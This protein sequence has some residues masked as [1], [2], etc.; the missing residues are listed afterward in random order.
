MK[1][2]TYTK[3]PNSYLLQVFLLNSVQ[4]CSSCMATPIITHQPSTYSFTQKHSNYEQL[5]RY[6]LKVTG[7]PNRG[8][9]QLF[10]QSWKTQPRGKTTFP[11]KLE[12]A[13]EG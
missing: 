1:T 10:L 8:V 13:N 6:F 3:S 12:R 5:L 2:T 4:N 9:K 7:K 11:A